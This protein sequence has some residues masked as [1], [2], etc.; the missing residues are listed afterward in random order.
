MPEFNRCNEDVRNPCVS[1]IRNMLILVQDEQS[2][3]LLFHL[4]RSI[5]ADARFII[6]IT[7]QLF[8]ALPLQAVKV[9]FVSS[10]LN[11]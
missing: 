7:S 1:T 10:A 11:F 6:T 4:R 5:K 9:T 2:S 8:M 3:L